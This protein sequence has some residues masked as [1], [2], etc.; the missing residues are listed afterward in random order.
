MTKFS[1]S[2]LHNDVAD[3][4]TINSLERYLI[5]FKDGPIWKCCTYELV[6]DRNVTFSVIFLLFIF[7]P[8]AIIILL[9]YR[10][11][12]GSGLSGPIPSEI[13]FLQNLYDLY[14]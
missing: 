11:I 7:T 10:T 1:M 5:S 3:L 4:V 9:F 14:V 8:D 13:S 12:Q 6:L 2:I